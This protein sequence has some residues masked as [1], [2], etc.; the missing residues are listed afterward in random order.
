MWEGDL[1]D[2]VLVS[3]CPLFD[4][5]TL[6]KFLCTWFGSVPPPKRLDSSL[7]LHGPFGTDACFYE[8]SFNNA[9]DFSEMIVK[10]IEVHYMAYGFGND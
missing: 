1:L 9:R 4:A 2:H 3:S 8:T 6:H 10:I 5:I 7:A